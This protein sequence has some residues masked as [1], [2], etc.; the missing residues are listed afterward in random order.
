MTFKNKIYYLSIWIILGL[1]FY[2]WWIFSVLSYLIS[3]IIYATIFFLFYIIFHKIK[4]SKKY[5]DYKNFLIEFIKKISLSILIII[6]FLWFFAYYQNILYPAKM[7]QF[8]ISNWEKI[9]VFQ[10]MS[11]IASP[12]FYKQVKDEII[13][14][15][16]DWYVY[17]Y[18]WVKPGSEENMQDFNEAI[19]IKFDKDLYK[20]FSK[21]YWV[22][23][24]DNSLFLWLV[25][26][27]DYN[28]DLSLDEIMKLYNN[29]IQE[30]K[31]EKKELPK[32]VIDI[33]KEVVNSLAKL[34]PKELNII[35][36]VNK[37][38]LNLIM[39][40]DNIQNSIM[41]N[42]SNKTLF[43]VILEERNK[44]IVEN[45]Y[46]NPADKIF[47][48]YWLMHFNWVLELLKQKDSKWKIVKIKYFYPI[49]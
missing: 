4:K 43:D 29:Q 30:K 42:F 37:A 47:I 33:N 14:Y 38:L 9:V 22:V 48:T 1:F 49:K 23:N 25:N 45:I 18:E 15:K 5:L 41:N 19:G 12:S 32:E 2:I 46:S 27:K 31:V 35:R 6:F 21:L 10:A 40:N 20:N 44:N 39:K 3:L 11:H 36:F 34:N 16:K 24:Q 28:V 13:K 7:P 17:F 8:T 26:D